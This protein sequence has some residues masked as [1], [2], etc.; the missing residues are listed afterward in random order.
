MPVVYEKIGAKIRNLSDLPK[1]KA[2]Y[3]HVV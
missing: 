3:S 1:M 2:A